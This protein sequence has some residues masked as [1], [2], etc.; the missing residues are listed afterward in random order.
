M[1]ISKA[2]FRDWKT[3]AVTI[4]ILET[5]EGYRQDYITA[6]RS[7]VRAGDKVSAARCEGNIEGIENLLNIEY[8]DPTEG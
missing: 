6:M 5:L 8:E 3:S 7:A 2:E 4:N 1:E